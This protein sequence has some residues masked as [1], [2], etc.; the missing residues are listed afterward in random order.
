MKKLF[1]LISLVML[2]GITTA[3]G[4]TETINIVSQMA[5]MGVAT[6]QTIGSVDGKTIVQGDVT[7]TFSKAG[8]SNAPCFYTPAI[9]AYANNTITVEAGGKTITNIVYTLASSSKLTAPATSTPEGLTVGTTDMTWTGSSNNVV[10]NI[11]SLTG[12]QPQYHVTDVT[13]TYG[14]GSTSTVAT[15]VIDGTTP[16][17]GS[18]QVTITDATP[19]ASIFYTTDGTAPTNASTPYT[20]AFTI[21]ANA[22]IKAIAYD[23]T[24][25]ASGV[26]TKA[27]EKIT[28]VDYTIADMNDPGLLDMSSTATVEPYANL[29]L[30]DAQVVYVDG[31]NIY[32]REGDYAVMFYSFTGLTVAAGDVLNGTIAV[33]F[34]PYYGIP[35]VKSNDATSTD[36]LTIT[37]GA[38][39][40]PTVATIAELNGYAHV[41]DY[42]VLQNVQITSETTV[43]GTGKEVTNTYATDG[44]NRIQLFKGTTADYTAVAGDGLFYDITGLF[45][46]I[47]K[48]TAEIQPTTAPTLTGISTVNDDAQTIG[49]G[50]TYNIAGQQVN[51]NTKGIVIKNGKKYINK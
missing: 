14:D 46:N 12:N 32:V 5:T 24:G 15:P 31:S 18:T 41:A 2:F 34:A 6:G 17:V 4:A 50:R 39:V 8:G 48:G 11:P 28:L 26:A 38:A 43:D 51:E 7:L 23:G 30:T 1:T 27:F 49:D 29:I 20:G 33:A 3:F 22:T 10:I 44:T 13:V 35:E 45:N 40:E 21:N 16:F 37:T 19:N 36:G 25:A 9:R 42:V 47:Y